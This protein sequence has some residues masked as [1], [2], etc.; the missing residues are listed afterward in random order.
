MC[1]FNIFVV[2]SMNKLLDSNG[3]VDLKSHDSQVNGL[4]QKRRNSI[5]N[6]LELHLCCINRSA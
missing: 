6:A 5:V 1:S 2:V 4:V 3:F